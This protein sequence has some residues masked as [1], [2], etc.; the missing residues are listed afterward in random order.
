MATLPETSLA[1]RRSSQA[2]LAVFVAWNVLMAC[3]GSRKQGRVPLQP[4]L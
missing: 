3:E 4:R 2:G 1:L